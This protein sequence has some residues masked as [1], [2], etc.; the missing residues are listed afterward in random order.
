MRSMGSN[1]TG[2]YFEPDLYDIEEEE[3]DEFEDETF[4]DQAVI[5]KFV[6]K[7]NSFRPRFDISRRADR[8]SFAGSSNRYDLAERNRMPT[9]AKGIAP[10]SSRKLYPKGF[11]GGPLGTGGSGGLFGAS[12][13]T[14]WPRCSGPPPTCARAWTRSRSRWRRSPW[15]SWRSRSGSC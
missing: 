9:A 3:Q 13:C 10:F 6:S 12:G 15:A 4:D 14:T 7:I 8:G 11:D 1:T 2:I 5:D